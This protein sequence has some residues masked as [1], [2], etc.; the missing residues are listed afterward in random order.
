MFEETADTGRMRGISAA[1]STKA[2]KSGKI[3]KFCSK[4]KDLAMRSFFSCSRKLENSVAAA[5]ASIT[6]AEQ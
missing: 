4:K 6:A 1:G 3:E 5:A 2:T